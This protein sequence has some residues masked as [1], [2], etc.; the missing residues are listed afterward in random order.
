[1]NA[2]QRFPFTS[3]VSLG[4]EADD[5]FERW[6]STLKFGPG[7]RRMAVAGAGRLKCK[8]F[9]FIGM[10]QI[11]PLRVTLDAQRAKPWNPGRLLHSLHTLLRIHGPQV[12]DDFEFHALHLGDIHVQPDVMLTGHHFSRP[13]WP[14]CDLRVVQCFDHIILV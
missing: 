5:V 4:I 14:L 7:R 10:G 8:T 2:L 13:P 12:L 3:V 9:A 11:Q 1:M 6:W